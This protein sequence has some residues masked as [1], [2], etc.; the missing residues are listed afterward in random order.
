M[1]KKR[2][3]WTMAGMAVRVMGVLTGCMTQSTY[4]NADK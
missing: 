2:L 4:N 3:Y 1:K